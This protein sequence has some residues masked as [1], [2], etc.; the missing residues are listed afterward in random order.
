M[1]SINQLLGKIPAAIESLNDQISRAESLLADLNPANFNE[2]RQQALAA[3]ARADEA[4]QQVPDIVAIIHGLLTDIDPSLAQQAQEVKNQ[5]DGVR[6]TVAAQQQLTAQ[7]AEEISAGAQNADA[8][9][10]EATAKIEELAAMRQNLASCQNIDLGAN[11]NDL[12]TNS[13]LGEIFGPAAVSDAENATI[14][15]G[16]AD[17]ICQDLQ[18]AGCKSDAQCDAGYVCE[19]GK[20]VS[21]FDS[22]YD[23]YTDTMGQRDSDRSQDRADQVAADQSSQGDRSG[24]TAGDMDQDIASAQDA[25]AGKCRKDSQCPPGYVCRGG[26]CVEKVYE[27]SNDSDCDPGYV[28]RHGQCVPKSGCSS[29]AD[30]TGGKVCKD[31]K[32]VDPAP[33][34]TQQ[35]ALVVSPGNKAVVLNETVNLKAIY[36]D[37]DGSTKDVTAEAKWS[38]SSTFSKGEIGVYAV[39]A[40]YNNLVAGSQ[41]TVVQEKGM[42]DITVNKKV[43]TVT[44]WDSGGVEDGDMIDIL[45]NGKAVFPGITLT[46]AKQSRTITM[47]A[48]VIVVGFKALNE[49]S[50]PPNTA[51][52]TFSAVTAGKETQK[53]SLKKHQAANMNVTYKP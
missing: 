53:Y 17:A 51:S 38:P 32:C 30:C 25:V 31:G 22:G 21:P 28:C 11:L 7:A 47:N 41:I 29:D 5:A 26:Q 42:D 36:T 33:A 37:T 23:D 49:G 27:C 3:A 40:T 8:I 43:I 18:D 44:F 52:V 2:K 15:A 6:Q 20:C 46:F 45:I 35:A 16:G 34:P 14:C 10:A 24:F 48:D 9:A 39:T 1:A 19:N 12:R 50:S 4:A 13:D